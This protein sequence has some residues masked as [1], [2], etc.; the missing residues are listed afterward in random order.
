MHKSCLQF[1][2]YKLNLCQDNQNYERFEIL[3]GTVRISEILIDVNSGF[4]GSDER[5]RRAGRS[6]VARCLHGYHGDRITHE[7]LADLWLSDALSLADQSLLRVRSHL[8]LSD[9]MILLTSALLCGQ[10]VP[11]TLRN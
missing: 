1:V 7:T 10:T 3:V 6:I 8:G 2:L 9:N 5:L 11:L 4:L